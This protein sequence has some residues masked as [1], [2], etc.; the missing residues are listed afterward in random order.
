MAIEIE[1]F[2]IQ[3]Q[4]EERMGLRASEYALEVCDTDNYDQVMFGHLK[5]DNVKDDYEVMCS[6]MDHDNNILN[7]IFED[8]PMD[9]NIDGEWVDIE[10]LEQVYREYGILEDE[11]DDED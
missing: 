4:C 3:P 7:A 9:V 10:L 1:V 6:I 5:S 8:G 2:A 11:L